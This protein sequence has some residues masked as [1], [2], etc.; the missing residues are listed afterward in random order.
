VQVPVAAGKEGGEAPVGKDKELDAISP[1]PCFEPQCR[2]FMA[3]SPGRERLVSL[4]VAGHFRAVAGVCHSRA[5]R[6]ATSDRD[7]AFSAVF[8]LYLRR[9]YTRNQKRG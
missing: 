5:G 3:G 1:A 2:F 9:C 7:Q 4:V 6:K 8:C